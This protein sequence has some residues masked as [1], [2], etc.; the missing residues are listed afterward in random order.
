MS[1]V[2]I[3]QQLLL[4]DVVDVH[5]FEPPPTQTYTIDTTVRARRQHVVVVVPLVLRVSRV[6]SEPSQNSSRPGGG[7]WTAGPPS[8]HRSTGGRG[9]TASYNDTIRV[10]LG[11]RR[12]G[13]SED[14][15][16][17]IGIHSF[18]PKMT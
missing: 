10:I 12:C 6:A 3:V 15:S 17:R 9:G 2:V 4:L 14:E 18:E 11:F 7:A 1:P 5:I 8:S 13:Q 16:I